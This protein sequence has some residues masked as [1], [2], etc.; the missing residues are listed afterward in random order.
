MKA[1]PHLTPR[2]GD[3]VLE[4]PISPTTPVTP[5][6]RHPADP[7]SEA[8]AAADASK[9][10]PRQAPSEPLALARAILHEALEKKAFEPA[11]LDVGELV[12]Y[13]DY[14]VLVSARNPRQVRAVADAV[15]RLFKSAEPPLLP[16]GSEG[17]ET[18][19]WVLVDYDDVVLHVFTQ[20]ARGFYDLDGLWADAPRLEVPRVPEPGFGPDDEDDAFDD[21]DDERPLFTLP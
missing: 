5:N 1:P 15:K 14:V 17:T 18:G 6:D 10:N 3:P 4:A 21:A 2:H 11:I 16:I 13:T 12:G 20:E 9:A 7:A 8:M 19:R